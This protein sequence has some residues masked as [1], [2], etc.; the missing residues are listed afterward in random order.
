MVGR[1]WLYAYR[2]RDL[3]GGILCEL[4][5]LQLSRSHPNADH[6]THAHADA[7]P[8]GADGHPDSHQHPHFYSNGHPDAYPPDTDGHLNSYQHPHP[9]SNGH[10]DG[11][12]VSPRLD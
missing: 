2:I 11:R 4:R 7:Y 8:P 6:H 9:Y 1:E 5:C 10:A 3:P 12:T